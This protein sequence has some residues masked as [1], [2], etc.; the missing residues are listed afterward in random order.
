MPTK[1]RKTFEDGNVGTRLQPPK[2]GRGVV[3][4]R[5]VQDYV[6]GPPEFTLFLT[7]DEAERLADTLDEMLEWMEGEEGDLAETMHRIETPP[8][9]LKAVNRDASVTGRK[10]A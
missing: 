5:R 8:E 4:F 3:L 10:R 6:D 7:R 2:F 9:V 1:R